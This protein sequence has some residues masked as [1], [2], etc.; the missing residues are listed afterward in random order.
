MPVLNRYEKNLGEAKKSGIKKGAIN[1][2]TIGFLWLTVYC[3]YA[4]GT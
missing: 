2:L 1:G 3:T 4:L